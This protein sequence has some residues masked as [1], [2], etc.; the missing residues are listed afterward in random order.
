[1]ERK[2]LSDFVA[3]YAEAFATLGGTVALTLALT[4]IVTLA[5]ILL[6]QPGL[7]RAEI[8]LQPAQEGTEPR[9]SVD[10]VVRQLRGN[11]IARTI[12]LVNREGLDRLVLTGVI[13]PPSAEVAVIRVLA[14]G[15][16]QLTPV[17]F[18]HHLDPAEL[19]TRPSIL[20][21]GLA[22]QALVFLSVGALMARWR[23]RPTRSNVGLLGAVGYGLSG[24]GLAVAVGIGLG[25]LL[26]WVGLP[27]REQPLL[28]EL[29]QDRANVLRLAPW[30]VLAAPIA[31]EVFF[32]GYLFR[33]LA[34]G[35]GFPAGFLI[36]SAL[37]ALVHLNLSGFLVYLAV[38]CIFALVYTRTDH[39]L[40]PITA[41]VAYNGA[42]MTALGL[43]SSS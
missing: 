28:Q 24:G 27:V 12:D 3:V 15:G 32:R 33:F 6:G 37:F 25:F 11:E 41:H 21:P 29:L 42:L 43:A 39:I 1:M 16:Y 4:L 19:I 36:S 23:I 7:V 22:I 40:A 26:E 5:V 30:V 8:P 14:R 13:S 17:E 31:E 9:L 34:Q 18:T 35:A 20:I 2:P 38:G 10:D